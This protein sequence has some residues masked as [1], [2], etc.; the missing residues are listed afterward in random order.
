MTRTP[1]TYYSYKEELLNVI[2]HGLGLVLSIAGLALLVTYASLYGTVWH[3]VS[4]SIFGSSLVLLY[5]ASTLYHAAK[6]KVLRRRLNV[7]DHAAIYVLIAGTYTPFCLVP[8]N[9]AMGWVLFGITWGLALAGIILKIFF[10]G[11]YHRLSTAS[12]V[13]M[14]WVAVIAAKQLFETLDTG[15]LV[16][17]LLGGISYT[18]G[19]VFYMIDRIR[20]NH[21]IF[22]AWVLAG[23]IFHF[24]SVFFYLL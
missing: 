17:L 18:V 21:A 5:L 6:S 23:S 14:G 16:F 15:G 24:L 12:Y 2:S 1:L 19:A 4:F 8:L 10:T 9:G 7:L 22:H 13:L 11:R 20:Y 3:I